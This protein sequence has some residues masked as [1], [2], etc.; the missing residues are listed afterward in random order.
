MKI[1]IL[2][3]CRGSYNNAK[4]GLANSSLLVANAL[5]DQFDVIVESC[6]DGNDIDRRV[7]RNK[8]DVVI[9]QAF[10]V[11]PEKARELQKLHPKVKWVVLG[12]SCVPF[13]AQE[14]SAF[15]WI[16]QLE[17]IPNLNIAFNHQETVSDLNKIGYELDYLPN[18]YSPEYF[19]KRAKP[20]EAII[21]IGC[22]GSLRILKN[23]LNQAVAAITF[24]ES[25]GK[26]LHFYINSNSDNGVGDN[27]L[28][29]MRAIFARGNHKL[30]EINWL[31]HQ[32]F[33][34]LISTMDL[35][36]QVSYTESFNITSADFVFQNV[37]IIVS[38]EIKFVH[39]LFRCKNT[40]NSMVRGL[41]IAYYL[42]IINGQ[43]LN[44][45]L[46][47]EHNKEAKLIWCNY[48]N[49]INSV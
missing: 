6:I 13:L 35:G 20:S 30:H 46:L 37:P 11:T 48:L 24:A 21:R 36:M 42:D 7:V 1:L 3:K 44:K 27:I 8:P 43:Y 26:T 25:I 45:L 12:H 18:I 32:D 39:A 10:F 14:G 34:K 19:F 4:F 15:T 17:K 38:E 49:R 31:N 40:I 22:F 33:C 23:S 2:F 5:K 29:N 41:Y 9:L 28:R 47:E 16:N